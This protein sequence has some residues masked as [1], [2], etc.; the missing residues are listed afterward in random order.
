MKSR[1]EK[2]LGRFVLAL[3]F[4]GLVADVEC[5]ATFAAPTPADRLA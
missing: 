5:R 1:V 3:V 4:F 2:V